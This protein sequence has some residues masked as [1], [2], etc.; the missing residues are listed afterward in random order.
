MNCIKTFL[1]T[2][3]W[4]NWYNF[5]YSNTSKYLPLQQ[6]NMNWIL[7]L[8]PDGL[9]VIFLWSES[10]KKPTCK[11]RRK[12]SPLLIQSQN[13]QVSRLG[14]PCVFTSWQTK[15]FFY[16]GKCTEY[17]SCRVTDSA[18]LS[19]HSRPPSSFSV[20]SMVFPAAT[21]NVWESPSN[22]IFS[23]AKKDEE[24]QCRELE[25]S[26]PDAGGSL[27]TANT[28]KQLQNHTEFTCVPLNGVPRIKMNQFFKALCKIFFFSWKK[29]PFLI[30]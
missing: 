3:S 8:V 1:I 25:W 26:S 13:P 17:M 24:R 5:F 12:S 19:L 4:T 28:Q 29:D 10:H 14:I 9:I 6:V 22:L 15:V 7:L 27:L 20:H 11:S 16:A 30:H 23:P 18:W 2:K 21:R